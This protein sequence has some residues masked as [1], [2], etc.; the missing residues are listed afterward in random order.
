MLNNN[1]YSR[2]QINAGK[3]VKNENPSDLSVKEN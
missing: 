3:D 2:K 1:N